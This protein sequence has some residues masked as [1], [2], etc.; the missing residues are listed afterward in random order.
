MWQATYVSTAGTVTSNDVAP[1]WT[2]PSNIVILSAAK[3]P[4][5]VV[6]DPPS[7]CHLA[8]PESLER[9]VCEGSC[10]DAASFTAEPALGGFFPS[11]PFRAGCF[12]Q[13]HE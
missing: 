10:S 12:A 4:F 13:N 9:S 3:D 11:A 7:S 6:A 5:P 1:G 8:C 2:L